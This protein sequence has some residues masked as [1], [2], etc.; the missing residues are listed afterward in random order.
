MPF[1]PLLTLLT[2]I[3]APIF[4]HARNIFANF[5]MGGMEEDACEIPYAE[6]AIVRN[7]RD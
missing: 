1:A 6:F 7:S 5:L 2:P 3:I 4:P